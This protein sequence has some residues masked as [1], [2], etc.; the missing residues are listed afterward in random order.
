M[1][2]ALFD[3]LPNVEAD[4]L[5]VFVPSEGDLP[6]STA[7]VDEN[8]AGQISQLR[9]T[10][11]FKASLAQTLLLP[12]LTQDFAQA[13][14]L[15]GVG[16]GEALSDMQSRKVV[17]AIAAQIKGL[18]FAKVAVASEAL[19]MKARSESEVIA[20]LAQWLNEGFYN[21]I[22]F[23]QDDAEKTTKVETLLLQGNDESALAIG[24][25][26]ASGSAFARQLG[27]LPGNVCTPSYLASKAQQLAEDFSIDV[28][29]LDETKMDELGMHCMLSV[30]RGSDQPSYLIVMHYRGGEEGDAPHVLLGK[31][32]TFD[33]G[34]IS[35]KPGPKMDEMKYDM[36]GAASVF[37]TMKAICE[38]QPKLNFTAVVAA[39]ENMPSGHATKPGDIVKTMSGKTVEILNTDAEGRLVLCDALTY[40]ERFKPKSVVDIATLT[41]A[42]VVALGSVNS[43]MYANN[44][45]LAE[46]LKGASKVAADKLWQMPLDEEYQQQLDSNFADIA[47]IGGP[48]A[49]SVTA[50]C[51]LSRFTESYPWAHLD[52]AGTAW[53]GG[54]NKGASGRPVGL[55]TRYLLSKA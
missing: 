38:L 19:N 16:K 39:A 31:G 12:A 48:E 35:L 15:V 36:C 1:N 17:A 49:G 28:E 45:A 7:W 11:V 5:V 27:N 41:G 6:E 55:L 42:C 47:N 10:G 14:L 4:L 26:T 23:K 50:A 18:P 52:I 25:A 32:I 34:G 2:M 24:T 33:T 54:A 40:I 3:R 51:F 13:V 53:A 22:G 43:G 20:L 37:G 29:L 21:F 46:E 9:E 8:A 30:G 44:E